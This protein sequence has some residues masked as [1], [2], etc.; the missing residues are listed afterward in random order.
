MKVKV[1]R[2]GPMEP[3]TKETGTTIK[4]MGEE[5][6]FTLMVTSTMENGTMTRR[7]DKELIIT[8]TGL[9]IPDSGSMT[10]ST[11]TVYRFGP[12]DLNTKVFMI[13]EGSMD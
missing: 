6:L 2:F 7:Q 10:S 9:N 4:P 3:D 5:S 8:I 13:W 12:M 11:D 1:Y